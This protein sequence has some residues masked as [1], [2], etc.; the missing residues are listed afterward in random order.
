MSDIRAY[1]I[2]PKAENVDLFR[3]LVIE[4]LDD[5]SRWRRNYSALHIPLG[6]R[7][8]ISAGSIPP[9]SMPA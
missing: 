2:G 3:Q 1:M 8:V 4:A 6:L 7:G 5:H 9:P